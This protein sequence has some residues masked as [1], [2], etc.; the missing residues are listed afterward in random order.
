M[1]RKSTDTDMTPFVDV[2]F[3]ILSFFMLA[4]KFKPPE[5][6]TVNKPYSVSA[7]KL[8][9]EDAMW[10]TFDKE[11]KV[12]F[13]VSSKNDKTVFQK[14]AQ[15]IND[16]RKLGL[17]DAEV[18]TLTMTLQAGLPV[19]VPFTQLKQLLAIP[20]QQQG[21]VKQAGIPVLDSATNELVWWISAGKDGFAGKK[22]VLFLIK[23]DGETKFPT[24]DG[25]VSALK[26]NE[27]FKYN[28]VT[29]PEDVPAGT[30]L[31]ASR[32][33]ELSEGPKEGP[34]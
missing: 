8:K 31:E 25:V 15:S 33:K 19:G 20:P 21:A 5:P 27:V 6:V 30:P 29:S 26:R 3:L 10:V 12:F 2:A 17:S 7:D 14:V 11:G 28:L 34:K 9:E 22:G 23:G 1:P 4:T 24:F 16:G 18:A 32:N 13:S